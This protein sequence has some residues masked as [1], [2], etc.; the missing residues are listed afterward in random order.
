[1]NR[2]E[3]IKPKMLLCTHEFPFGNSET[4]FIAPEFVILQKHF[5]IDIILTFE[6]KNK[7]TTVL[8]G[9]QVYQVQEKFAQKLPY[10]LHIKFWLV[11]F[12]TW[13]VTLLCY[14]IKHKL[15]VSAIKNQ[16]SQF[17]KYE[18]LTATLLQHVKKN[19]PEIIYSYWFDHWNVAASILKKLGYYKGCII[20]RAHRY[21]LVE[22]TNKLGV[23]PF[24]R[25]QFAYTDLVFFISDKLM[26]T[27]QKKYPKSIR[28]LK[29]ARLGVNFSN[30]TPHIPQ[31]NS[32]H[33]IS[34]GDI[35][36][37]K[38]LTII[39]HA[40]NKIKLP[41]VWHH[42]GASKTNDT[43]QKQIKNASISYIN[44]GNI[45]PQELYSIIT[46]QYFH[47]LINTSKSEGIPVSM[48]ES[49]AC[50]IPI[51]ATNVGGVSEIV[52]EDTGILLSKNI[53]AE[54]LSNVISTYL[55]NYPFNKEKRGQI[56][57]FYKKNYHA[58]TNYTDFCTQ[59]LNYIKNN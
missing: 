55:T 4:S 39:A 15:G 48:M 5:K 42:F 6:S 41:I 44:Y 49:I 2:N 58:T 14:S 45:T 59:I 38:N 12:P 29:L 37:I 34:I 31:P 54:A 40:L 22:E 51:I 33:L 19:K 57:D 27:Y 30:N 50:G 21:E 47:F 25:L 10:K 3:P 18:H 16:I 46:S 23:F 35:K 17:K 8:E 1:M 43:L 52:N 24:H 20:S 56:T 32:H 36:P 9:T 7:Q 28:N 26:Q 53:D 11:I 13:L